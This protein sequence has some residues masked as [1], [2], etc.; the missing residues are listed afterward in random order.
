MGPDQGGQHPG[1]GR[2]AQY[3]GFL[4]A[5]TCW[6]THRVSSNGTRDVTGDQQKNYHFQEVAGGLQDFK[7]YLFVNP[8]STFVTVIHSLM[9]FVAI[10]KATQHLQGRF[11]GF[12]GNRSMTKDPTL[13]LLP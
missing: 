4:V 2:Q 7:T 5:L 6:G 1:G 11:V 13:I 12:V 3:L 10:N 8:G 9:K